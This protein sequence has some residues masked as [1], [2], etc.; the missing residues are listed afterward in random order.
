MFPAPRDLD[1]ASEDAWDVMAWHRDQRTIC[2][3]R[4]GAGEDKLVRY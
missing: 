1:T 2:L 3:S 4:F